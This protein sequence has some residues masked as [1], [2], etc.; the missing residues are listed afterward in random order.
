MI[1]QSLAYTAI[2][3]IAFTSAL[4]CH[5]SAIAAAGDFNACEQNDIDRVISQFDGNHAQ[6]YSLHRHARPSK[7]AQLDILVMPHDR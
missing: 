6:T 5:P 3:D 7:K 2:I 1:R 4:L